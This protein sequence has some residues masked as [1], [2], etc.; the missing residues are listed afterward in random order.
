MAFQYQARCGCGAT[1]RVYREQVEED[2]MSTCIACGEDTYD[3][4]FESDNHAT[5]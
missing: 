2:P 5:W 1:W 3:L 4:T